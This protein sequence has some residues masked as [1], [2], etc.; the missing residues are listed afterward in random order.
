ME[1]SGLGNKPTQD[2]RLA[3]KG[4]RPQS[5]GTLLR[6]DCEQPCSPAQPIQEGLRWRAPIYGSAKQTSERDN[7]PMALIGGR[8]NEQSTTPDPPHRTISPHTQPHTPPTR[9]NLI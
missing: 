3:Q 7:H 8:Y 6:L 4:K 1:P 5:L 9:L 2:K